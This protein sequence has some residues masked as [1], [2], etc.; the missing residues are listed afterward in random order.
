[1]LA[2]GILFPAATFSVGVAPVSRL[3]L[4]GSVFLFAWA[5]ARFRS[6]ITACL[7]G[8]GSAYRAAIFTDLPQPI[9]PGQRSQHRAKGLEDRELGRS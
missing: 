3:L 9:P 5:I 7:S 2:Q 1:M 4:I 8:S 6:S